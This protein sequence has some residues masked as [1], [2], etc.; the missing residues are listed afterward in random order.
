LKIRGIPYELPAEIY[1]LATEKYFDKAVGRNIAIKSVRYKGKRREMMVVYEKL[2]N[3]VVIV[4][5]H[6][7][8]KNQKDNRIQTGRWMKYE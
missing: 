8:K 6:P 2:K 1:R 7:L 5:I 3:Q 4:T